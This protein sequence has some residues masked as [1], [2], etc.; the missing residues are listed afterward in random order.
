[1][2]EESHETG[3]EVVEARV[4]VRRVDESILW[5]TAITHSKYMTL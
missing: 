5:T 2:R 4:A 1:M 3:T